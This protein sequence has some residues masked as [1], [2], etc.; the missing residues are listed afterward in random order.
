VLETVRGK[1]LQVVLHEKL[2]EKRRILVLHRNEP[3]Q[4]DGEI[5]HH[6][7][8]PQRAAQDRPLLAQERERY[9]NHDRQK[10]RHRPFGQRGHAGKEVD[11]EEP[12]LRVS[13]IPRIPAQQPDG[14]RRGHLHIGG[15]A[16]RKADDAHARHGDQ[17][18]VQV[19]ARPESPHVQVDERSHDECEA[20]RRQTR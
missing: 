15:G 2:A 11:I 4:H 12:E 17:R 10:R 20:R 3:R 14:E 5:E 18:R 7:R 6:A 19:P 13:L 16:A 8:P 1:P 9:H